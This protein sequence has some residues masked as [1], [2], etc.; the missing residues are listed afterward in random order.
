MVCRWGEYLQSWSVTVL[1]YI[2][3]SLDMVEK[4]CPESGAAQ[5]QLTSA[6][7]K[8]VKAEQFTY[9]YNSMSDVASL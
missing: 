7:W 9:V 2:P 6:G 8:Q 5:E 3:I 4:R 1:I